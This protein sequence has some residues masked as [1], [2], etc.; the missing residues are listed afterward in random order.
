MNFTC[1]K[2]CNIECGQKLYGII[3]CSTCTYEGVA[4]MTVYHIDYENDIVIFEVDQPC[5]YVYCSFDEMKDYVFETES[6]AI[7]ASK[8]IRY[9]DGFGLWYY[10]ERDF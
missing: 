3:V 4:E 8:T 1:K 2:E 9:M 10:D 6:E 7:K 5:N